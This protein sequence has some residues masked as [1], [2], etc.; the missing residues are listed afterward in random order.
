[1]LM[2][3]SAGKLADS[4]SSEAADEQGDLQ[5]L[6]LRRRRSRPCQGVEKQGQAVWSS[7]YNC[8][9]QSHGGEEKSCGTKNELGAARAD[10][11]HLKELEDHKLYYTRLKPRPELIK[12]YT[13]IDVE[14]IEFLLHL[15][16]DPV[17]NRVDTLC[18]WTCQ[19]SMDMTAEEGKGGWRQRMSFAVDFV[20]AETHLFSGGP[21]HALWC[22]PKHCVQ[23]IQL[24][25]GNSG[26]VHQWVSP[27]ARPWRLRFRK[28]YQLLS[29]TCLIRHVF[30]FK[31]ALLMTA[32]MLTMIVL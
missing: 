22:E 1:M 6:S 10:V 4:E 13:D 29:R 5:S 2:R 25:D 26:S 30:F 17:K 32:V 31:F 19:I 9:W 14:C 15:V 20:Q 11:S 18:C 12:F 21:C 16:G 23:I 7:L 8:L 28:A 3:T 24:L 27:L